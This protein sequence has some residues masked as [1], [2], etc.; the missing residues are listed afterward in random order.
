LNPG[1]ASADYLDLRAFEA[2]MRRGVTT[3]DEVRAWLGTPS[4][5]A[6]GVDT[7]GERYAEWIYRRPANHRAVSARGAQELRI[8]FDV[9]GV[10]S[11][12]RWSAESDGL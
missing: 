3:P 7:E 12:Y 4:A 9:L 2:R 10:V 1:P 11:A 8:R 5:F 6:H